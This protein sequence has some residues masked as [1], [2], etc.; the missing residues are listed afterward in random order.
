MT[1]KPYEIHMKNTFRLNGKICLS[2]QLHFVW[3]LFFIGYVIILSALCCDMEQNVLSSCFDGALGKLMEQNNNDFV[4]RIICFNVGS[5]N[6][7]CKQSESAHV[8]NTRECGGPNQNTWT[9]IQIVIL[10]TQ[11]FGFNFLCFHPPSFSQLLCIKLRQNWKFQVKN[12]LF[13]V[14][15]VESMMI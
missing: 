3:N 8:E 12:Y 7:I 6:R 11:G 14:C 10:F 4:I 2:L 15:Y 13:T 5:S 9:S 1:M